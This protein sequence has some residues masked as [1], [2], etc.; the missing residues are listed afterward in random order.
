MRKRIGSGLLDVDARRSYLQNN[1][2]PGWCYENFLQ[3]RSLKQAESV[4]AQLA[5][6][7]SRR[8]V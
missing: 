1:S 6:V 4:R 5:N 7:M 8:D 2:D 3:S